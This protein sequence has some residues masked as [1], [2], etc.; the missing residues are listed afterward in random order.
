LSLVRRARLPTPHTNVRI[1]GHEVDALW[2]RE[3]LV[4]EV[5]G[6]AFHST[7]AAFE[8]DRARDAD[9]Q[10]HGYRVMRVTWRQ[11]TVRPEAL[12]ARIGGALAAA[13]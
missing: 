8:R 11:L 2:P 6:F 4:V 5:D 13:R 1:A 3:R 7:R 12:A 9:L 10:A